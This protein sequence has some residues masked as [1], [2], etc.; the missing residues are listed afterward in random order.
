MN[1]L[2]G[3]FSPKI[4]AILKPKESRSPRSEELGYLVY[5]PMRILTSHWYP[6]PRRDQSAYPMLQR[7][8]GGLFRP[9]EVGC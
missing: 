6:I 7:C 4:S 1:Q 9:R 3:L 2:P 5:I 8:S